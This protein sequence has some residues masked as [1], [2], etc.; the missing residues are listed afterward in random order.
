M[1]I[2]IIV[3][4]QAGQQ[5][6]LRNRS[7]IDIDITPALADRLQKTFGEA[8]TPEQG[9]ARIIAQ[10]RADGDSALRA[11]TAKTTMKSTF[12]RCSLMLLNAASSSGLIPA[13]LSFHHSPE[14]DQ[15]AIWL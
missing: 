6:I 11:L 8:A 10:V 3:G 4:K 7:L 5:K 15:R 2:P 12:A 13:I 1:I 9:V 14:L